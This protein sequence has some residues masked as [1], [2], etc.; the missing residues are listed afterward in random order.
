M[1]TGVSPMI[2]GQ[3]TENCMQ[4]TQEGCSPGEVQ[5]P[6]VTGG[7][8]GWEVNVGV[9]QTQAWDIYFKDTGEPLQV[10]ERKRLAQVSAVGS[11]GWR[12]PSGSHWFL[13]LFT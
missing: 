13:R 12:C 2:P 5:I 9:S 3:G 11:Q 6:L 8:A 10:S 4:N 7:K 1:V